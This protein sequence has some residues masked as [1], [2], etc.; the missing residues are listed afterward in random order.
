MQDEQSKGTNSPGAASAPELE[1]SEEKFR[2]L[3]QSMPLP[4]Y[5]WQRRGDDFQL[6]DYNNAAE[7]ITRGA[8]TDFVGLTASQMYP[9]RP[10]IVEDISRSFTEKASF[11]REMDY[12]FKSTGEHKKLVVQYAYVPPDL[13]LVQT[14]DVT[15]LQRALEEASYERDLTQSLLDA[16]ADTIVIFEPHTLRFL[17]WNKA[18]TRITGYSDEELSNMHPI[19][20]FI[21]EAD[22]PR[23][24]AAMEDLMRE[25]FVTASLTQ[26]NKDGGKIPYE[27]T[28]ALTRDKQGNPQYLIFIGRDITERMKLEEA[29]RDSEAMYRDLV[30]NINDVLYAIDTEGLVTYVSPAIESFLGLP[31]ERFIGQPFAQYVLPEDL[32]R[33]ADNIRQLMS[34]NS[35]GP[36]E[37]RVVRPSGEIRWV[38]VSSRPTFSDGLITGIQGVMTD[39][40]DVKRVEEQLE[41]AATAAERQRLAR[42]LHDS[43][44]QTL[45]GISL[46]SFATK[47][48]LAAGKVD[49][50][51]EQTEVVQRLSQSAL[52]DMRLL[53]F[54]LQ[55]PILVEKGLVQTLRERLDLVE[56]R[57]GFD[58]SLSVSLEDPIP[59]AIEAELYAIATEALNNTL[60]HA[61]ANQVGVALEVD[62][63]LI[64]LEI[65]DDGLGFD[66]D[67]ADNSEGFGL[68]NMRE[69]T[70]RLG[71]SLD[72]V[73]APG[74]GTTV[75]VEIPVRA[76]P[77]IRPAR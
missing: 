69:R 48:A 30:E 45:Y 68:G 73:S 19:G 57:S 62:D 50:A 46:Y 71:G 8:I 63:D 53:I 40:T 72:L 51:A 58:T 42:E 65:S 39:I 37:Y 5:A 27:Y 75:R 24:E 34:G 17:K 74:E 6:T 32:D 59:H 61:Q 10:D 16:A 67:A 7:E 23:A 25:E 26:V 64:T 52:A 14:D 22:V 47:E 3:F 4:V 2:R 56:A 20:D 36:N 35:P 21:D 43:A 28:G 13:V 54:E 76:T 70:K 11:R 1:M 41:E 49:A 29:L 18:A 44:T 33:A 15:E 66:P 55:P 9:D 38:R 60:K 31:P 77:G 12:T